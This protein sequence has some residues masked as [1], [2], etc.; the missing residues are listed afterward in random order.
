MKYLAALAAITLPLSAQAEVLSPPKGEV[1]YTCQM[2]EEC[3]TGG[4]KPMASPHLATITW[5]QG[6]PKGMIADKGEEYE[7]LVFPG[8]G[9]HE[10]MRLMK[11]GS[12]GFTVN[13]ETG[14]VAVRSSGAH[15]RNERGTCEIQFE[16][17]PI[18][19]S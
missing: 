19:T 6:A 3:S 16:N 4:C 5:E 12:V 14:A 18:S 8:L 2:T 1:I 10:F 7:V 9:T 15:V 13:D 11:G 17:A